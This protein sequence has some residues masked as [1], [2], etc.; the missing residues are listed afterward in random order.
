[1]EKSKEFREFIKQADEK[2]RIEA[3]LE[4]AFS[5][6]IT[7]ETINQKV[8][9]QVN[10]INFGIKKI[11]SRFTEKSKNYDIVKEQILDSMTRYE[12]ALKQMG[13]FYDEKIEQLVI[14][15]MELQTNLIGSIARQQYLIKKK[16]IKNSVKDNDKI[17]NILAL[18]IKKAIDKIK[19]KKQKNTIDITEINKLKDKEEI[20]KEHAIKIK[21][22]IQITDEEIKANKNYMEKI[23]KEIYLIS[24]EIK[25]LNERKK[26]ALF[27]AIETEDRW[28][29]TKIKKPRT[30]ER[31][32]RFFSSRI[33]TPKVIKKNLIDP[34]NERINY[35]V[36]N[37]LS[38]MK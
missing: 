18:G 30:F 6:K 14:R 16:N 19:E 9:A 23:N 13:E 7:T 21:N 8:N 20:E 3:I 34:L 25:K 35:F 31:I 28:M 36:E 15:K 29:I 12:E 26:E 10:S 32:T 38:C 5:D 2:A 37:E 33:N 17:K 22:S 4:R 11:N 24:I 1:M 27:N